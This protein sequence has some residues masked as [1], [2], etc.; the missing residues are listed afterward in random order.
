M[1][2][3]QQRRVIFH[4]GLM[5][6]GT[7]SIQIALQR[8][9]T[10]MAREAGIL[11]PGSERNHNALI[12]T[13]FFSDPRD[14][15]MNRVRGLSDL[16]ALEKKAASM[17]AEIE[18]EVRRA[19]AGTILLSSEIASEPQADL[20]RLFD[21]LSTLGDTVDVIVVIRDPLA[22]AT[23]MI[24]QRIK[25][26]RLLE[27]LYDDPHRTDLSGMLDRTVAAFGR[28]RLRVLKFEDMVAAPAGVVGSFLDVIGIPDGQTRKTVLEG[29][30]VENQSLSMPAA[31][32]LDAINRQR[33]AFVDG[34]PGPRR[35]F[36]EVQWLSRVK[37]PSFR[38]PVEVSERIIADARNDLA[39]LKE[40]HGIEPYP[41]FGKGPLKGP[42]EDAF[43]APETVDSLALVL[44]DLVFTSRQKKLSTAQLRSTAD[45]LVNTKRA[46]IGT[47]LARFAGK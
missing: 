35:T 32:L 39:S 45:R 15:I 34:K 13:A 11:Y 28:E 25:E 18:A 5:K 20:P 21:W 26:G 22:H 27:D 38:V 14:Y 23:S 3:N 7:S 33:P 47:L 43:G 36:T 2:G 4:A 1:T 31:L 30:R 44:S 6:T 37:G 10:H 24:Q 40:R 17:R 16:S 46:L 41:D 42:P 29:D 9:R 19:E 12:G 8:A